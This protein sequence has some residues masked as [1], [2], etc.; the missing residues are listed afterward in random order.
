MKRTLKCEI[1]GQQKNRS[2]IVRC[3]N[4]ITKCGQT[5]RECLA[6]VESS[7]HVFWAGADGRYG[8]EG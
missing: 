3:V 5:C 8:E 2:E 6:T 1:C 7:A 4:S